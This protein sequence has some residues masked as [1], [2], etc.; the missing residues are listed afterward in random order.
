MAH[1]AI[2]HSTS[3]ARQRV[4]PIGLALGM[5][6]ALAA[7][8]LIPWIHQNLR[9]AASIWGSALALLLLAAAVHR[10]AARAE[11]VLRY[12]F[13]P[14]P[15]H[16]VQLTMHASIYAYWGWY[17]REVYHYIPLILAQV[18]F[19]Y[20]L[21]MLVSWWRSDCWILGFGPFPIVFSTNLFLWFRDDWF[22][23]QFLMIAVAVLCK[24]FLTWERD[25]R[26]THIFNPS[27]IA[28]A[29]FSV[30]LLATN[31]TAI[32]WG[33]A[34]SVSLGRPP[35]MF[36][37]IFATG[38]V[39]QSLFSVTLVTLSAAA[40]LI[41]LNLAYTAATGVYYFV[42]SA[43][44]IA[45][46]L[47]LHLLVTDPATS[48]RGNI[49][50][51][52]FG[53]LYGAAVF[54]LYALLG[55][56]GLP[57]F[58]D[59]LLCVPPMNLTV[60]FLDRLS[61]R[62]EARLGDGRWLAGWPARRLNFA[63]MAVW[64]VLFAAIW[65]AHLLGS[66]H[67][68]SRSEFW[69]QACADSRRNA[70]ATWTRITNVACVHGA[71]SACM[72]LGLAMDGA[73][74]VV[75]NPLEQT[76]AFARACDTKIGGACTQLVD[77][78]KKD[79]ANALAY[80]CGAADGES[81]FILASLYYAGAGVS[82]DRARSTALFRQSCDAGWA[83]GCGGLGELFQSSDPAAAIAWFERACSAGIAASCAAAAGLYRADH[84]D[85]LALQRSTQACELSTR[86]TIDN[87]AYFRAG[88]APSP[89]ALPFCAP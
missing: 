81:C 50:K 34:V 68:G 38:I 54:T 85:T 7:F 51:A 49:G 74:P 84:R 1:A 88:A 58:Y 42:D 19:L 52:I 12:E 22:Y 16:Y 23:L 57:T 67:P 46:F 37:W 8:T 63:H 64:I 15:V 44:P 13:V 10:R 33:E 35:Y 39:V 9:L 2:A 17:W 73:L 26:R 66:A 21:D 69:R 61:A 45:V 18:A 28:L 11:R 29:I 14:K 41:A 60:R 6:A 86:A 56:M 47:G 77:A 55:A 78:V 83:R 36:R 25:G 70:C 82:K 40:A 32:S 72:Q 71:G 31:S 76:K 43:I 62:I 80:S 3:A 4:P 53:A 24:H 59:K 89:A 27:A 75:R 79:G 87:A 20:A 5:T 30:V 65:N 48:P